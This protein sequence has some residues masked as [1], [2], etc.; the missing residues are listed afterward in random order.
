MMHVVLFLV[1]VVGC[2]A[3]VEVLQMTSLG[4]S[5]TATYSNGFIDSVTLS[6][7][8]VPSTVAWTATM[9]APVRLQF[10]WIF[11][12]RSAVLNVYSVPT[13]TLLARFTCDPNGGKIWYDDLS[14]ALVSVGNYGPSVQFS[15]P[16][17]LQYVEGSVVSS[18]SGWRITYFGACELVPAA[19]TTPTWTT[20]CPVGGVT[21]GAMDFGNQFGYSVQL[22]ALTVLTMPSPSSVT[23]DLAGSVNRNWAVN[24]YYGAYTS[25]P[26]Q[27]WVDFGGQMWGWNPAQGSYW[28][29]TVVTFT[30][31]EACI[32]SQQ[33][34]GQN[35]RIIFETSWVSAVPCV[36]NQTYSASGMSPCSTCGTCSVGSTYRQ[37][38]CTT[39]SNIVCNSCTPCGSGKY[40]SSACTATSDTGCSSCTVCGAGKYAS[41]GCAGT[42]DAVCTSC[43]ACGT[44]KYPSSVCTS[45]SNTGCT[46][47]GSCCTICGATGQFAS[48]PCTTTS[49]IVCDVCSTCSAGKYQSAACSPTSDTMC[50]NCKV[51]GAGEYASSVC[52]TSSNTVCTTCTVCGTGNYTSSACSATSNTVCTACGPCSTGQYASSPCTTSSNTVC[53]VCSTC[54][55]GQYPRSVCNATSNTVCSTCDTCTPSTQYVSSPC[56]TTSNTVCSACDVC[57]VGKYTTLACAGTTNTGCGVCPSNSYCKNGVVST[58]C[59]GTSI[60]PQ[61]SSSFL[62]CSCP[63]GTSGIVTAQTSTCS[64]CSPGLFCSGQHCQC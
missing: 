13:G 27:Y 16:V 23:R 3:S 54:S 32:F 6:T 61:G 36:A 47:C 49:N 42:S 51:C 57:G 35:P 48:A 15:V 55:T 31:T 10:S 60:S 20:P 21:N 39:T 58:V 7:Y 43:T 24:I 33:N 29:N 50:P 53:A 18:G 37:S 56:T 64:Q 46:D 19:Q 26:Q 52:T 59:P 5:S 9:V 28:V 1:G 40:V 41:S 25:V 12:D 62:N 34:A 17:R 4:Q 44:G 38:A 30:C 45:T 14:N 2:T 8:A 22:P 63:T 11:Q